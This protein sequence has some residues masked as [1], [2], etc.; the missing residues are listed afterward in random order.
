MRRTAALRE[1]AGARGGLAPDRAVRS[2]RPPHALAG[3]VEERILDA[4]KKVFLERGFEG[5]SIDE[6][7]KVARAGKPTIYSRFPGK[8]ALFAAVMARQV[9]ES[10]GAFEN[11]EPTGA[12]VEERLASIATAILHKVLAAE[13]VG[14]CRAS[15]AEARRFPELAASVHRMARERASEAVARLLGELPESD[16][17][18]GFAA[19]RRA[20]TA[21]RY[22]ELI[23][24][25]IM[26]QALFGEDLTALAAKIEEHAAQTV[27]FF[28][29][30]CRHDGS[31]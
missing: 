3:A 25:P 27:A 9:R 5:A 4:A 20:A 8:E 19:D 13:T 31:D 17:L 29:A 14:L 26:L 28:L 10:I 24:L 15:I 16:Q 11:M 1:S 21:R 22:I 30:A 18:P 12:T 2:G 6:I 23:V 7:A